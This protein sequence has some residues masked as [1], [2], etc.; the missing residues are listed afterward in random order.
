MSNRIHPRN[1][2]LSYFTDYEDQRDDDDKPEG[3]EPKERPAADSFELVIPEDLSTL[4]DEELTEL[5][6]SAVEAFNALYADGED[7][8][9]EQLTALQAIAEGVETLRGEI[10]HREGAASERREA[11]ASLAQ[12]VAGTA[13][14]ETSDDTDANEGEMSDDE[15]EDAS[16]LGKKRKVKESTAEGSPAEEPIAASANKRELRINVTGLARRRA[17]NQPSVPVE[18][19][20]DMKDLVFA[21]A[22]TGYAA[23]EGIGWG[24]IGKIVD[25]RLHGYNPTVFAQAARQGREMRQ[26]FAVC[27]FQKPIPKDLIINS[28][29]PE[30][31]DEVLRRAGD[32]TRLP[33]GSLVA[34]GGWCAPSE[35]LYDLV[36]LESRDGVFS[37]PE[38]GVARGGFKRTLGPMFS[39]IYNNA[40][41]FHYTET[42][43]QSGLYAAGGGNANEVQTVTVTGTPTGGTYTLTL[44]GYSVTLPFNATAT[45]V[46]DALATIVGDANVD[47]AGGPHPGTAITVT[48]KGELGNQNVPQMTSSH[49][50]TGGTTPN[51]AVTTTTPGAA[52]T[53]AAGNKPCFEVG[54]PSF[55]EFRLDT[56]GLCITAGLL[57]SKGYPEMIARTVRGTMVAHDHRLGLRTLNAVI[58][59]STA[60]TM[61][62]TSL[63]T[64]APLLESV[65]LQVEYIRRKHRLSRSATL[66]AVFDYNVHTIV[67]HDI[68]KRTG[69]EYQLVTDAQID[70]WFGQLGIA[71]Q[72]TYWTSPNQAGDGLNHPDTIQYLLYPAGTWVR[73]TSDVITM[74]TIYDTTLTTTQNDYT[75]LFTEEG[76]LVAKMSH[77]SRVVTVPVCVN[78]ATG[79]SKTVNCDG[80]AS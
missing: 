66:E 39:D 41:F 64:V 62:T 50:L 46:N 12:R 48:F 27:S 58:A 1:P 36:E 7:L 43:D 65:E 25:R 69:I 70:G 32:E 42:Q 77:E 23:G 80:V 5:H 35:V 13:T 8:N 19:A 60:V 6:D 18:Q 71:P 61:P 59:G 38:V 76:W 33:K 75:A 4:G 21:A 29:D 44:Y 73:G 16:E 55:E 72:F 56:D 57:E 49:A 14:E 2:S 10:E 17:A 74:D 53:G 22:D 47:A 3:D 67:R 54:C 63:G 26:Q 45:Q 40:N 79:G 24:D 9:G 37:L 34:S 78:G 30:H 51:V 31:V 20:R 68:A 28:N 11:A 15:D 52:G